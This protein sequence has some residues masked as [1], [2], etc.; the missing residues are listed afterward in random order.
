[1]MLMPLLMRLAMDV[2]LV[3]YDVADDDVGVDDDADD[4]TDDA[5]YVEVADD[6]D[7][8]AADDADGDADDA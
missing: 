2:L 5:A 4:D 1:M 8:N 3:H 6:V 7:A